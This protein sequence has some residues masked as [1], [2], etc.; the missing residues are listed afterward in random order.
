MLLSK[1]RDYLDHRR[2]PFQELKNT[3]IIVIK[4]GYSGDNII[5]LGHMLVTL[6][7]E[8]G[9]SGNKNVQGLKMEINGPTTTLFARVNGRIMRDVVKLGDPDRELFTEEQE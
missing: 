7:E 5:N 2:F 6:V 4:T 3:A 9:A 1:D 8:V